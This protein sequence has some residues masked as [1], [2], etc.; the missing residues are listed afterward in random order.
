MMLSSSSKIPRP[1]NIPLMSLLRPP[2]LILEKRS[3]LPVPV[4]VFTEKSKMELTTT[5][6]GKEEGIFQPSLSKDG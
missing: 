2:K 6:Y 5:E 3:Q 4:R 1:A